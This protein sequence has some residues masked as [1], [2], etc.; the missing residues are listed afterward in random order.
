MRKIALI[1]FAACLA[2]GC[3]QEFSWQKFSIDSHRTGV[4]I[5][6][7]TDYA[8]ALGTVEGG[9]YTAPNGRTFSGGCTPA[10][11]ALLIGAQ[12][13]MAPVKE[14]IGHLP[15]DM[16]KYDPESPL[17]NFVVDFVR[18]RTA[19][20][21]G[22]K[23]DV[24][25]TNFGGIRTDKLYAGPLLLDDIESM[26]PFVNKLSY[27]KLAGSD[28]M[29]IMD[30]LA[31]R[32]MQCLSG[33]K[34]V[35]SDGKVESLQIGGRPFDPARSYGVAT[36]DFLLD[37]GDSLYVAR[38]ARELIITDEVIGKAMESYIRSLSAAGKDIA[39]S[40]DGRVIVKDNKESSSE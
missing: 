39:G 29:N 5:V 11:A 16:D 31:S 22:K 34:L 19:E 3:S 30:D 40:T 38:G 1:F 20:V 8:P 14:V 35:V 33:V 27:V 9:V 4:T 26:L 32:K 12:K 21:T 13:E 36:V 17:S 7:G 23:V 6:N 10:V 25:I 28:L 37:G 24:A 2:A 18:E 15:E